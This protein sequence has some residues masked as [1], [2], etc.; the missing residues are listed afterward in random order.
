MTTID[1]DLVEFR[2]EKH[3]KRNAGWRKGW[4]YW[5]NMNGSSA[6]AVPHLGDVK[7]TIETGPANSWESGDRFLIFEITPDEGEKF[8][9]RKEGSYSSYDDDSWDGAFIQVT[10]VPVNRIEYQPVR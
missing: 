1:I 2:L 8:W 6:H 3:A 4:E 5:A 9:A 10:P 7:V